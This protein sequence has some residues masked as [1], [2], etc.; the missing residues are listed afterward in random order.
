MTGVSTTAT[1]PPDALSQAMVPGGFFVLRTPLLPFDELMTWGEG[2]SSRRAWESEGDSPSLDVAWRT[3]VR[4]LR[5]RL[6]EHLAK[7]EVVHALF[8]ASP[9]L[10]LGLERWRR[11]PD[12]KE[13]LQAERALVRY[14]A[15]M[16][17]RPTPFGLFSGCS[18]GSI[19]SRD[20]RTR[21]R[22]E[23]RH[24]YRPVSRLDF[25]Y[26]FALT[27]TLRRDESVMQ[28]LSYWPNS[29]LH[30]IADEWHYLESRLVG[31]RRTQ[32]VVKLTTDDFLEL[33]LERSAKGATM[34]ELAAAL[35]EVDSDVASD[36]ALEYVQELITNDVLV[37]NLTPCVTED[38]LDDLVSQLDAIPSLAPAALTLREARGSM[39][40]LEQKGVSASP[41][42]YK[43]IASTLASLPAKT[44]LSRLFQID[45]AKPVHDAVLSPIVIDELLDGLAFLYRLA[46]PREA[47]AVRAFRD[48]FVERYERAHVPLLDVV[49]QDI[50]IGFGAAAS[51][52]S[53]LLR[54]LGLGVD[55]VRAPAPVNEVDPAHAMLTRKL[56]QWARDGATDVS[57]TSADL[58][59]TARVTAHV[60]DS[61]VLF[62][63]LSAESETAVDEGRF[64]IEYRGG[65]GPGGARLFGRFCHL[66]PKLLT[67]VRDYLRAEEANDPDALYVE[68]IYLPDGRVGNILCR[69]VLREYEL[70]YLGRSGAPVERQIPVSDLLVGVDNG[71]VTLY[72]KKLGRRVVPRLTT[73][74]N[75]G[76]PELPPVYRFLCTLQHQHEVGVP[77]FS[78]GTLEQ[79]EYLPRVRF[80]RLVLATARWLITADETQRV[81]AAK[82]SQRFVAVQRLRDQR[83]LPRWVVFVEGDHKLP[84][85]L[86]NALSVDAFVHVLKRSG[87]GVLRELF[88]SPDRLCVT[89]P[90]GHFRHELNIPFVRRPALEEN[91]RR[92][93][94]GAAVVRTYPLTDRALPAGSE[95]L[96][97]KVYGGAAMLDSVL[98][99]LRPVL[100]ALVRTG[101][102]RRWFFIRY[103]DPNR[104]VRLRLN[105]HPQTL[106]Q[107][108]LPQ[109]SETLTPW[110]LSGRVSDLQ[111]ETYNR[112]LERYGGVEGTSVAEDIFFADSEAVVD[113]LHELPG[114]EGQEQRWSLTLLGIDRLLGDFGAAPEAKLSR[115]TTMRDSAYAGFRVDKRM[116]VKL[117]DRFRGERARIAQALDAARPELSVH[118]AAAAAFER[119]S[120]HVRRA[121]ARLRRLE[122]EGRL[123]VN[124]DDLVPSFVHMHVNRMSRSEPNQ[125][126]LVLY[127]FVCR[128]YESQCA[129]TRTARRPVAQALVGITSAV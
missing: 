82:G 54:G 39:L 49:D 65:V 3:D 27:T 110:V 116:R 93:A 62:A 25:D 41:D 92:R 128:I 126:E 68:V 72:S 50:G 31:G 79:L 29:S 67:N 11:D 129:R 22:L 99:A 58:P 1:R 113:V 40:A 104:H 9:S 61:M 38:P 118:A 7:P 45:L 74:H 63:D 53:G 14:W 83:R 42:D 87:R 55:G 90:E 80:G 73:A 120:E 26:L 64:D 108:A 60:P 4:L 8:I 100:A 89:G 76:L 21:L 101:V 78:W 44:E 102:V 24:A 6:A 32:H 84:L 30:R 91:S 127:D 47:D 105:G 119:R 48:A 117:G 23:A 13:G 46:P 107:D 124:V 18:V 37:T 57:L 19:A 103:W 109:I 15:R 43:A 96:Y 112:E 52:N 121:A 77:A 17:G 20:G 125:H 12:S 71:T 70:T 35:Q 98:D 75:Y 97:A 114:D 51:G 88:P 81:A 5:R 2:L 28:Q 33:V 115:A 56:V 111:L 34:H 69:P 66:D 59:T 94:P 95:W 10:D 106:L 123:H 16:C 86:D 122:E 36:E 85:D